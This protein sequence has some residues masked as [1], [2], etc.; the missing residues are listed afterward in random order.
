[1]IHIVVILNFIL[2]QIINSPESLLKCVPYKYI[3]FY[4]I[5]ADRSLNLDT[6][7]AVDEMESSM[8]EVVPSEGQR[9]K[10]K[11][12]GSSHIDECSFSSADDF[13]VQ[14]RL[15]DIYL[16]IITNHTGCVYMMKIFSFF[17]EIYD[18]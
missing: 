18:R 4:F 13:H 17:L 7:N 14:C 15:A 3:G 6:S 2:L 1:M 16:Y 12:E 5:L 11:K 9:K 10:F 8:R